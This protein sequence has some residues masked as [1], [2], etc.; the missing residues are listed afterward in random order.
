MGRV[1]RVKRG[2][3]L[4][5]GGAVLTRR[6]RRSRVIRRHY[7]NTIDFRFGAWPARGAPGPPPERAAPSAETISSV[8]KAGEARAGR[9]W[10]AV[11]VL[12][13]GSGEVVVG[14]GQQR[15]VPP[16]HRPLRGDPS[17]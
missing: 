14:W 15:R 13:E 17:Q 8:T 12:G 9:W 5:P 6:R 2:V 3:A 10:Q 11:V 7:L 1:G 16:Y 4:Y